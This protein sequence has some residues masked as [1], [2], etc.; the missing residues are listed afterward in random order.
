MRTRIFELL[1]AVTFVSLLLGAEKTCGQEVLRYSILTN[2]KSAGSEVDTF[3]PQGRLDSTFEYNDRGRGPKVASRYTLGAD[4][5]PIHM[6]ITGNDY[7]KAPVDEHFDVESGRA[8]WKSTTEDGSSQAGAFYI[9]NNGPGAEFALL[10]AALIKAKGTPVKLFPSG[11]AKLER[12]TDTAIEDHGQKL[13]VTEY[14]VT[15]LSFQP[16]TVWLDD[17]LRLFGFPGKCFASFRVSCT[18]K[19]E[20]LYALQLKAEDARYG[21][22]AQ[23]LARRVDHPVAIEHVR[24][25]DSEQAAMRE[26][27]TVIID[28]ERVAQVGSSGTTQLPK[29]AERIDGKGKTLL[30]GLFDMH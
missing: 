2:G 10:V 17:N 5:F 11:E 12:L 9:S 20:K 26:D 27:Q 4:G 23:E 1:L 21:R 29:N 30:P 14:A 18:G 15:G 28:G 7:L 6:E 24:V 16:Q 19:N 3:G 25:F 22:L 13:H 8:H